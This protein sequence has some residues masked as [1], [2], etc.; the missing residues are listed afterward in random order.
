MDSSVK[1]I[2]QIEMYQFRISQIPGVTTVIL[3]GSQVLFGNVLKYGKK[4][5][6]RIGIAKLIKIGH[7]FNGLIS[8]VMSFIVVMLAT[9][10]W[11]YLVSVALPATAHVTR[12]LLKKKDKKTK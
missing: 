12:L 6:Q 7:R 2:L 4:L 1:D 9:G 10:D 8:L 3:M 11:I 5:L